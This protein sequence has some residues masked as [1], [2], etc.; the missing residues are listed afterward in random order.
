M[1]LAEA[2]GHLKFVVQDRAPVVDMGIKVC[3]FFPLSFLPISL[4]CVMENA[5]TDFV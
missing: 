1:Q 4:P 5:L 3:F 2:F